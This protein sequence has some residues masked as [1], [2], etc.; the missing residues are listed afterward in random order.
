MTINAAFS[1]MMPSTVVIN[2]VQSTD[3]YGKRTFSATATSLQCRIQTTRRLVIS[4]DGQQVPVEGT[5]YV[6]GTSAAT[7][8]DKLTLPDSSVVPI[9]SVET[10]N[11]ESGA[12]ATVISYGRA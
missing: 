2:A 4:E 12:Y 10:R 8:N 7:V 9:V 3:A 6:F 5:V 11:D 1:S